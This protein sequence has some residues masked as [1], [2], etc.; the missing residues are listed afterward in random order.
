[1]RGSGRDS[2]GPSGG[3]FVEGLKLRPSAVRV[4]AALH[5]LPGGVARPRM[6]QTG[7]TIAEIVEAT[8]LSAHVVRARLCDLRRLGLVES[9]D[10]TSDG[11]PKG[12]TRYAHYL[13]VAGVQRAKCR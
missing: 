4:L 11:T 13:T 8:G 10:C 2:G 7:G 12:P 5:D 1:M 6:F 3:L 9:V